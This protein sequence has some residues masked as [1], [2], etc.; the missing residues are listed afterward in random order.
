MTP[1]SHFPQAPILW[2]AAALLAGCAS[3]PAP[4]PPPEASRVSTHQEGVPGG[5]VVETVEI[6][7]RVVSI[8]HDERTAVL[9]DS[10][11]VEHEIRVGPE[12]VNFGQVEKGDMV[13]AVLAR[14]LIIGLAD[15]GEE[16]SDGAAGLV[17]LAPEGAAPGGV[18]A[19]AVRVTG[20]VTAIDHEAHTATL[21]F[22]DG[23]SRTFPVRPDVD[24]RKHSVGEAVTFQVTESIALDVFEP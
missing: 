9:V 18:M 12:A 14:E 11:G 8:D 24:L 20:T 15:E 1:R 2:L 5:V 21:R 17:A 16:P 3:S 23:S 4:V 10:E 7:A 19:R 13:T 6:H 22:A